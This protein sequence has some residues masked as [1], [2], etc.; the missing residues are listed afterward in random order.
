M[1][2]I[3]ELLDAVKAAKGI[4]SDYALAKALNLKKQ[5]ISTYY[6]R[7]VIPSEYACLEIAKA[8]KISYEEVSAIVQID[9]EKD[10]ERRNAWRDYY[11]SI[12]GIAASIALLFFLAVN[13][14]V[15]PTPANAS[16]HEL[17]K[18]NSLYY[19]NFSRK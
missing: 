3:P 12:G 19:V 2:T 18:P 7:K 4:E 9:A 15:T 11:K 6:K 16:E 5:Q 8:L 10:E 14:I 13:L 17:S 1:T